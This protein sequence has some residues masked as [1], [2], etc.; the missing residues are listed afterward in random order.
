MNL[1]H[2]TSILASG[3]KLHVW[4]GNVTKG[5]VTIDWTEGSHAYFWQWIFPGGSVMGSADTYDEAVTAATKAI[6]AMSND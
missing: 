1:S 3:N 4:R 6:D 5:S 2:H